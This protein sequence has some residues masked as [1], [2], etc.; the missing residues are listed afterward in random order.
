MHVPSQW[1]HVVNGRPSQARPG[2]AK[3]PCDVGRLRRSTTGGDPEAAGTIVLTS[4]ISKVNHRAFCKVSACSAIATSFVRVYAMPCPAVP[5]YCT[6]SHPV[7]CPSQEDPNKRRIPY[8]IMPDPVRAWYQ[9][10]P[11]MLLCRAFI[12]TPTYIQPSPSTP[13]YTKSKEDAAK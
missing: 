4:R 1:K 6:Q 3:R 11:Y 7:P 12:L 13:T 9:I 2:E 10:T 5:S 8:P